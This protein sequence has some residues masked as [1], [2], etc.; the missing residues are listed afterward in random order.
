[1]SEDDLPI[2]VFQGEQSDAV[3]LV[4]LLESEGIDVTVE[5]TFM[6]IAFAGARRL[7]VR[8][9]DAQKAARIVEGFRR[10]S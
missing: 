4:S 1:M 5:K 8:R 2:V 6:G 3:F 7:F 10:N 9:R